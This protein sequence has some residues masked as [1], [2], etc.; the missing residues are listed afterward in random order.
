M[1][2]FYVG[3]SPVSRY[4]EAILLFK[5]SQDLA[6]YATALEGAATILIIEAWSAGHGL[7]S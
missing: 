6:W 3:H 7:V 5:T 4:S 1:K 2:I